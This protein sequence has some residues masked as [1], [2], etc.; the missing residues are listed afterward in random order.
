[1]SGSQKRQHMTAR[2]AYQ[3]KQDGLTSRE[4]ASLVGKKPEQIKTLVLLGERLGA[5]S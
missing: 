4:I 3:L 1:M 5:A 2:R